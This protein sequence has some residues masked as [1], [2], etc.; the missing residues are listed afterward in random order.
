MLAFHL[1]ETLAFQHGRPFD[2]VLG[3]DPRF[4]DRG[5]MPFTPGRQRHYCIHIAARHLANVY[6]V[7]VQARHH[8]CIHGIRRAV[9]T[10]QERTTDFLPN[11]AR[12]SAQITSTRLTLASTSDISSSFFT[13][14]HM[15]I[16]MCR[17][18]GKKPACISLHITRAIARATLSAGQR[19]TRGNFSARYSRI[20]SDSQTHTS[21]SIS[22]GTLP[23]PDTEPTTCLKLGSSSEITVSSNGIL[24]TFIAIHGRI[25]HEE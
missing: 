3:Q 6:P 1:S 4:A 20:A 13:G 24:T 10:E 15:F 19:P 16:G 21:P 25:D 14:R 17:R 22:T 18:S 9:L 7:G 5:G 12:Q 11:L 8:R 23:V 2:L